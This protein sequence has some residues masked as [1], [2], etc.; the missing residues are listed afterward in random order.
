MLVGMI[1][2]LVIIGVSAEESTPTA[3]ESMISSGTAVLANQQSTV[4][5]ALEVIAYQNQM[6]I[7]GISGNALSF[8]ADRFM[9]AMNLSNIDSITITAL[10]DVSCGA[11]Y[12][13]S[14][15]VSV[16]QRI[17]ASN[18]SLMMKYNRARQAAITQEITEIVAG[19]E[20]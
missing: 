9:C 2:T 11:L 6:A 17:S 1:S 4:S 14:D 3:L 20:S 8:S 12:I 19:A 13:G 18:I 7:A 16:G 15:A 10:P 5:G